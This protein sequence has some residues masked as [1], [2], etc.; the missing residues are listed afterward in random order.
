MSLNLA[1]KQA[2]VAEVAKVAARA[3]SA[4]A[5][6]YRGLSVTQI[7]NLRVKARETGVYLR[8]VKNTLARRALQGTE[9]E[10]LRASLV[11][12][13]ILA[14]SQ[15]DPGAAARLFKEFL[16]EKAHD[17]LIV[18]ALAVGGQSFPAS[19]LDRL[20]SLPTRNEAISLLMAT[21][22][23]PLDKLA[24][25]LNEIPGKLVRTLDAVRQQ[26]EEAA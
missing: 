19:E 6:E 26:R 16:K 22:R 8:V 4:I 11:G 1:E 23:A 13:L 9:F 25:T 21:L 17:K 14:F 18:K 3:H 24:Q 10:C 7:T 2:V 5:A 20:A 15:E 12:P